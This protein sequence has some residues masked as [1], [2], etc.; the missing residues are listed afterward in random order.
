MWHDSINFWSGII[1]THPNMR[2]YNNRG[3][4][5]FQKKQDDLALKDFNMAIALDPKAL[6]PYNNRGHIYY[7]RYQD[8]KAMADFNKAISMYPD[9]AGTYLNR[10]LLEKGHQQYH[11]ALQDALKAKQLGWPVEDAYIQSLQQQIK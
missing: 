3:V 5:Y 11:G 9:Y 10:S 6:K 4:A 1:E 7:L 8:K 2:A